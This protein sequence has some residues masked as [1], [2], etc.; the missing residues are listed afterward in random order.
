MKNY[1]SLRWEY[2]LDVVERKCEEIQFRKFR[3]DETVFQGKFILAEGESAS[4][5]VLEF[6]VECEIPMDN[7]AIKLMEH[8]LER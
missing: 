2:S 1:I 4:E 7:S 3:S 6:A 8:T 5:T